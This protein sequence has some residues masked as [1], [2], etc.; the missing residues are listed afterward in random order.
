[1]RRAGL[2]RA[3]LL[4][5]LAL[6]ALLQPA[7]GGQAPRHP[8]LSWAER[9][10]EMTVLWAT[11]GPMQGRPAVELRAEEEE[12]SQRARALL[13]SSLPLAWPWQRWR[14]QETAAHAGG[15]RPFIEPSTGRV[16][17]YLHEVLLSGLAPGQ[18]Y[19]YRAG[20]HLDGWSPWQRFAARRAPEQVSAADP[21]RLL[22]VGDM[23]FLNAQALPDLA[24][25]V[26]AGRP[27]GPYDALLHVGDHAYDLQVLLP[28]NLGGLGFVFVCMGGTANP[29][30]GIAAA[31]ALR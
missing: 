9:P 15:S 21:L 13:R 23:G 31:S 14:R 19:S 2:R 28:S 4:L 6:A 1:M 12:P 29:H 24:Q 26:E 20:S 8:S 3:G 5:A 30:G 25:E 16:S 10:D 17:Q 11:A 18:R 27:S 22:L 7:A